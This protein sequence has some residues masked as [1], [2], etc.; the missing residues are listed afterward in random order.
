MCSSYIG[1]Y[2]FDEKHQNYCLTLTIG[3]VISISNLLRNSVYE[4]ASTYIMRIENQITFNMRTNSLS[5]VSLCELYR[6][7]MYI[8]K[9]RHASR[10]HGHLR[11]RRTNSNTCTYLILGFSKGL[12]SHKGLRP[13]LNLQIL[14][15][16]LHTGTLLMVFA[17]NLLLH[18]KYSCFVINSQDL[19]PIYNL[20]TVGR[21]S[22]H[23][24]S[25]LIE[26]KTKTNN[27]ILAHTFLLLALATCNCS[28]F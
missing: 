17:E 26:N 28:E 27:D 12:T 4:Q 1:M 10:C 5:V 20:V 9:T 16:G 25:Q 18:F 13:G 21:I 15:S 6:M 23:V 19:Y 11:L 7:Y 8:Q 3:T 24:L 22:C 14:F 2:V